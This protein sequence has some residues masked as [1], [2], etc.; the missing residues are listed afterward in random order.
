MA[1]DLTAVCNTTPPCELISE[2]SKNQNKN[3]EGRNRR[4]F[5]FSIATALISPLVY[6]PPAWPHFGRADV[7]IIHSAGTPTSARV[8]EHLRSRYPNIQVV[9]DVAQLPKNSSFRYIA[10]G[11]EALQAL[12][13]RDIEDPI[14]TL[15][16]SRSAY[17]E[18]LE[19]S[20][21]ARSSGI[22]A[23][24]ADASLEAQMLLA[25]KLFKRESRIAVLYS[26]RS[27]YLLGLLRSAAASADL[28]LE[29][30]QVDEEG[31][32]RALIQAR[33]AEAIMAIPDESIYNAQ[34]IRTILLSTYQRNQPVL[35]FSTSLVRAGAL[36]T[37]YST[38][39]DMAA[40]IGELFHE[41]L[42]T[43]RVPAAQYPKYF[44]V[45]VNDSVSRSLNIV[46]E[47]HVRKFGRKP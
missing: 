18:I 33:D 5:L 8:V 26:A 47:E 17:K 21:K 24:Y 22:T 12:V 3:D 41:Y 4:G 36:G 14:F 34:N 40:Q 20:G 13:A 31:I 23:I 45:L 27:A 35:G 10:V 25:R 9:H 19:N 30:I 6:S 11:P 32:N 39:E 29:L 16:V 46:I 2:V 44:S 28:Q 15:L 37:T 7:R 38:V 1:P 43:G 42:S